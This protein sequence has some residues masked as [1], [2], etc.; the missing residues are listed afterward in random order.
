MQ[1]LS[2]FQYISWRKQ[3]N[4]VKAALNDA[5]SSS[6]SKAKLLNISCPLRTSNKKLSLS[7]L[8]SR[9][10]S[11]SLNLLSFILLMQILPMLFACFPR[12]RQ[13]FSTFVACFKPLMQKF[14]IS[15]I[16]Q[17]NCVKAAFDD[18]FSSTLSKAKLFNIGCPLRA[19][20]KKLS[21]SHL[22]SRKI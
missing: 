6:L 10:I 13:N 18:V 12:E 11:R 9:R 14:Y 21:L 7:R 22:L 19:S 8:F 17:A 5:F 16:K 2:L 15:R 20:N 4:C 3:A 1:K